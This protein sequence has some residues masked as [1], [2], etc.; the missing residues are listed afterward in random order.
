MHDS[1]KSRNRNRDARKS[2]AAER[3]NLTAA[4]FIVIF[5]AVRSFCFSGARSDKSRRTDKP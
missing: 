2:E 5:G 3:I 4:F 1:T